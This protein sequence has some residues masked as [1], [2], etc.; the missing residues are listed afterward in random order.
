MLV[1]VR[2][3]LYAGGG[4]KDAVP[5]V[6]YITPDNDS[7][8]DLTGKQGLTFRWKN[9]PVPGG[10]REAFRFRLVKGFGYN[11]I[12]SENL[13]QDVFLMEIP[14]D[15]FEDGT[16]YSW[17]VQQRDASLMVWGWHDTWSFKVIKKR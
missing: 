3:D 9:Q 7:V 16:T 12:V 6:A 15:K 14:A 8:V 13:G 4:K 2:A 11:F 1:A 17:Y 10:G 5:N